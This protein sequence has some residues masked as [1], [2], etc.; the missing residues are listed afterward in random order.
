MGKLIG[1]VMKL[2]S[3]DFDGVLHSATDP[4]FINNFRS[5][6]PAWQIEVSLKAQG[7]FVWAQALAD[8]IES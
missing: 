7:R 8:T 4:V 6:A 5:Q 1:G 2:L 3:L